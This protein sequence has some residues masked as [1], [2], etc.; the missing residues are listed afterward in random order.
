[1]QVLHGR[2][3]VYINGRY[4]AVDK[5]LTRAERIA[6][7]TGPVGNAFER[8]QHSARNNTNKHVFKR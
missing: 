8:V 2:K 3:V 1:M 7:N 4:F 6:C 5:D